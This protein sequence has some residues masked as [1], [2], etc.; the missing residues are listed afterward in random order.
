MSLAVLQEKMGDVDDA[1]ETLQ[2]A[3]CEINEPVSIEKGYSKDELQCL[4]ATG[5]LRARRNEWDMALDIYSR[6]WKYHSDKWN[7][8]CKIIQCHAA[9]NN[10]A[11]RNEHIRTLYKLALSGKIPSDKYCREQISTRK[12]TILAFEMF[13]LAYDK[14]LPI[15]FMQW[16]KEQPN[17]ELPRMVSF[18]SN[19]TINQIEREN[20]H[21]PENYRLY[22]VDAHAID[23]S[24]SALQFL[25]APKKPTYDDMRQIMLDGMLGRAKPVETAPQERLP[26]EL[27]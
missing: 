17:T 5:V 15:I 25:A 12:G 24:H 23:G 11:E 19:E 2:T 22:H 21:L 13:I 16:E 4:F 27:N 7:L 8:L 20:G 14:G 18:G 3:V 26:K 6:A 10:I 1:M 9:L